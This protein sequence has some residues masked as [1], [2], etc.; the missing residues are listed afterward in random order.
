MAAEV[1]YFNILLEEMRGHFQLLTEGL[2]SL[3]ERMDR[4]FAEQDAKWE[5]RFGTLEMAVRQNSQD[6]QSLQRDVTSLHTKYDRHESDIGVLKVA[7][8][9][10]S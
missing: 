3:G 7:V 4:R 10:E 9:V 8:G 1:R 6:I 2:V 5:A